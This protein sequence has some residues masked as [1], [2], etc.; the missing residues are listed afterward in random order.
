MPVRIKIISIILLP[1]VKLTGSISTLL[2]RQNELSESETEFIDREEI[3][4]LID[5]GSEAGGKG[6]E[7]S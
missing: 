6:P 2:V 5:E 1:V 4:Y 7:E 3:H